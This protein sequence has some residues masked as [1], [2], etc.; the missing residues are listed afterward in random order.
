[1][2][3]EHS[4][5]STSNAFKSGLILNTGFTIFE[6]VI[7]TA[8][9]SLALIADG[10]HNLTDSLT[11]AIAFI[12]ERIGKR[13]A[14][15]KRSYGYGRAKIIASLLNAGILVAI[16]GFIGYEAINRLNDPKEVPG[17]TVALVA[18][19][20][21]AINGGIA[22]LLSKQKHNL[23]VRGAYTNMLYD[24]LSSVGAL[25]AG[26]AIALFGWT[27]LDSVVGIGIALMLLYAIL[28]IVKEAIHILLEGVPAGIDL[29]EVKLS[30]GK[31]QYVL[32]VDD[33]HA[34][35]IDNDYYA[36]SCHLVVDEKNYALSRG[37]VEKAKTL[38]AEEYGFK[39]STVEVELQDCSTHSEHPQT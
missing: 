23:N 33:V 38:L 19:V 6:L 10:T 28:S 2:S 27:W 24:T 26:F 29:N 15:E 21:I 4:H 5:S 34:W 22:Y 17:L 3:K 11:L 16:A 1:M 7:G 14:D 31:L 36:F 13:Q 37:A 9:G 39:H 12:A 35:T 8:T 25:I 20:G 32:G 18:L 30:L